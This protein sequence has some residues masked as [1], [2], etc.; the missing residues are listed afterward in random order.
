M[1]L[2]ELQDR[3]YDIL[4]A[5]DD[6]CTAEGVSY[7]LTGGTLL[8][9]IRHKGFIPWDDDVD[10]CIWYDDFPA[11]KQ[12]MEK[13]LPDY[14]RLQEPESMDPYFYDF[15][16]RVQDT[17]YHWHEP[18]EIDE[19][20]GNM[21]NYFAVDIFLVAPSARTKIG[22]AWQAI[23]NFVV[24]GLALGH[25]AMESEVKYSL[26]EKIVSGVLSGVGKHIP[27]A[28]IHQMGHKL[29]AN[30]GKQRDKCNYCRVCNDLP[31]YFFLKYRTEWF[32][33]T[34]RVPFRDRMLP[35]QSGYHEKLTMQYGNYMEPPKDRSEFVQHFGEKGKRLSE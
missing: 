14:Y 33:D 29:Y 10:I 22:S 6:A 31:K 11:F 23:K 5:I 26:P 34:V 2:A 16:A 32:V 21:Q 18:T 20:Y 17:R 9:A 35:V 13:H 1:E 3:L 8:G 30:K 12:A 4:C 27:M 28:K 24:Y 15:I 19:K 7:M 25:R